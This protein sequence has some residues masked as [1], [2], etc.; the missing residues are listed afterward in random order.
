M[1]TTIDRGAMIPI[2]TNIEKTINACLA[3][4]ITSFISLCSLQDYS[5]ISYDETLVWLTTP[6]FLKRLR[7]MALSKSCVSLGAL[8]HGLEWGISYLE[9]SMAHL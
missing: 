2:T 1:S 6:H 3:G 7:M 9:H 8:T 4:D 5:P